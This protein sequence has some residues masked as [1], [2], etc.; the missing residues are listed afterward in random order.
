MEFPHGLYQVQDLNTVYA[1]WG[2]L[3]NETNTTSH[4]NIGSLKTAI[5]EKWN[6]MSENLF[7][8]CVDTIIE[9]NS[10]DIE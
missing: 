10:S 1:V 7:Q 6:K 4:P 2:I 8:K 3:E 5:E 9:K